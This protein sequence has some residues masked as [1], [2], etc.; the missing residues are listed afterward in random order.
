MHLFRVSML[1]QNMLKV[2][3]RLVQFFSR[4][5]PRHAVPQLPGKP[6]TFCY[7]T[8]PHCNR[9]QTR[10]V[11][12]I[13][14]Q[15]P[16][17]HRNHSPVFEQTALPDFFLHAYF[18]E[19]W[20][21][22]VVSGLLEKDPHSWAT[23]EWVIVLLVPYCEDLNKNNKTKSFLWLL[24]INIILSP[25]YY[26]STHNSF[27][28]C[29]T[30]NLRSSK[31][32]AGSEHIHCFTSRKTPPISNALTELLLLQFSSFAYIL[33]FITT[34]SFGGQKINVLLLRIWC[35]LALVSTPAFRI[36]LVRI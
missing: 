6:W 15:L 5:T 17:H 13:S 23:S 4:K 26:I 18:L 32:T 35:L 2:K 29:T 21:V 30:A 24:S 28:R 33:T 34:L 14:W 31:Q 25:L 3:N 22:W 11:L 7:A 16:Q 8:L 1:G 20:P 12:C 19:Q 10:T 27:K 9:R 36:I